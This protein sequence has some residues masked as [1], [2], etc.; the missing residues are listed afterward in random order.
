MV[1]WLAVLRH[2]LARASLI[3]PEEAGCAHLHPLAL[4]SAGLVVPELVGRAVLSVGAL[5]TAAF[6]VPSLSFRTPIFLR[7]DTAALLEVEVEWL[8][9][10][11]CLLADALAKRGI[12]D[13]RPLTHWLQYRDAWN[14]CGFYYSLVGFAQNK[15][16]ICLGVGEL[17]VFI[18]LDRLW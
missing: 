12:P 17:K 11:D 16:F 15:F 1:A 8:N 18:S 4:A 10:F 5:A 14:C 6:V 2:A 13:K 9:A 7:A 3:V